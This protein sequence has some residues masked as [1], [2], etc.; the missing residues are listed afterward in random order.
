M[1]TLVRGRLLGVHFS[2][3]LMVLR[4]HFMKSSVSGDMTL[5]PRPSVSLDGASPGVSAAVASDPSTE[6]RCVGS[7]VFSGQFEVVGGRV[8]C[9]DFIAVDSLWHNLICEGSGFESP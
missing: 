5:R 6:S 4:H 7:G 8:E 2:R 3:F 9:S 1:H